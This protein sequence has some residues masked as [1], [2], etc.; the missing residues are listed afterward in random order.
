MSSISTL[1]LKSIKSDINIL[2][3]IGGIGAGL[4][5]FPQEGAQKSGLFM[6][7]M[8]QIIW[9]L[10]LTGYLGDMKSSKTFDNIVN[11]GNWIVCLILVI[12]VAYVL[13]S[14]KL[15]EDAANYP[16]EYKS[17]S[18]IIRVCLILTIGLQYKI[19]QS[20][21]S[22]AP[23]GASDLFFILITLFLGV[24]LCCLA[25]LV[26]TFTDDFVITDG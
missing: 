6:I 5:V 17:Y 3:T 19:Y 1:K 10:I 24:L 8:T 9:F 22:S 20:L 11:F 16:E 7:A 23:L 21:I 25:N 2:F 15:G 14:T 18:W 12:C 13:T 26:K 4:T